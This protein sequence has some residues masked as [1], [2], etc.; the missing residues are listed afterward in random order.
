MSDNLEASIIFKNKNNVWIDDNMVTS[1]HKCGY[2]FSF[3]YRR[4][5]CR[6]CGNIFCWSCC[7]DYIV[8]PQFIEDRPEPEDFWN[9]SRYV[10]FLRGD[11]E[12]VCRQCYE[13][14]N[15][16]IKACEKIM[17]IFNNPI[18][19]DAIRELSESNNDV[20]NHY[21]DHLR[22][23]Q[24]YLPN[25]Q[26]GDVDKNLLKINAPYFSRH[27]K[28]L[29][30]LIK[31]MDFMTDKRHEQTTFLMSILNSER[32]K[33]CIQ[34]Y[35]TR[36]CQEQL[37]IDDCINILYTNAENLPDELLKYLFEIISNGSDKIVMCNLP[38]FITLVKNNSWNNY[39]RT[40]LYNL[41]S[42]SLNLIYQTYWFLNNAKESSNERLSANIRIFI[43]SMNSDLVRQMNREYMF[44]S[45]LVNNLSDPKTYLLN[46]FHKYKP[47][48]LPYDPSYKIVDVDLG[49]IESKASKSK[50]V[51]ITFTIMRTI[52]GV[53]DESGIGKV[54]LLFKND[55]IDNDITVLNL[56]TIC[57]ILLEEA[58]GINF[59][60]ITYP[61]MPLTNN[62]GMIE[63]IDSA[64]TLYEIDSRKMSISQH[65]LEKNRDKIV[66][67]VID[68]Y[69]YSLISYTLYSYFIGLGDRHRHNIMITDDGAIFHI[70][71]DYILGNDAYPL[72]PSEIRLDSG[73]IDVI[74]GQ[75]G[76][77]YKT[78]LELCAKGVVLLRKYHNIFFILLS[79]NE[80]IKTKHL[81]KF[82]MSRFQP[83]Q[84]DTAAIQE[85]M[86]ILKKS[87]GAYSEHI[88]DFLHY[89]TQEKTV[90]HSFAKAF[91][92]AYGVIRN[93]SST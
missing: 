39:L 25:H 30:H 92:T 5:H 6:N 40:L 75:N 47:I 36:T 88:R 44:F 77:Q 22:N 74:G 12:L 70:D 87:N 17:N 93:L 20:K 73:M 10:P 68:R 82:I 41:L 71:F 63:I 45:G 16:K 83:R 57:D 31:S 78:Y 7:H 65:I 27:S 91:Q 80:K 42:R 60:T 79:Q 90:Q 1:C 69:M 19:I 29:V 72:S 9:I 84:F 49:S 48:S 18:S 34:L 59:Q 51:I 13:D 26:Y 62:S 8:I 4:H 81:E 24:Y 55:I 85:L 21:F 89:H 33:S 86:S 53:L 46:E 2:N 37:S 35:C 52:D 58:F 15:A 11:S 38:F 50:P 54:K 56:M 64:E 66:G 76:S 14:I 28:Y 43:D 67:D 32:N 61:I 23:I 3:F